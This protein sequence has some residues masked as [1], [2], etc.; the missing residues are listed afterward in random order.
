MCQMDCVVHKLHTYICTEDGSSTCDVSE[1]E[2][3]CTG[4][5]D[6]G[7]SRGKKKW[8]YVIQDHPSPGAL[9]DLF[10]PAGRGG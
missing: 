5:R 1:H 8:L 2:G 9:R 7:I 10:V 6:T 4:D 3:A